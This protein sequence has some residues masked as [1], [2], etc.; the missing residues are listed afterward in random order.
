MLQSSKTK[1]K[2]L[3]VSDS[4]IDAL[5]QPKTAE[6]ISREETEILSPAS[7]WIFE[8]SVNQGS[9][10]SAKKRLFQIVNLDK[11]WVEVKLYQ[12]SL[13]TLQ[14]LQ[15]FQ[16]KVTG[17]D[18]V[19]TAKKLLLY[20]NINPKEATATLRLEIDNPD[21]KLK[22]GM[23]ATITSLGSSQSRLTL[24][25]S[26]V[27]RKNG[28]WYAFLRTQFKGEYEPV[29][30]SVKAID[31]NSYEVLSGLTAEDEVVN[32]ALFM[33]DSDAQISGLY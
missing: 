18:R 11:V 15:T 17:S 27:I 2:L 9:A 33:M 6:S 14:T 32:N 28:Q 25:R 24:P 30:I 1:L 23:Y 21:G 19:Y 10:F 8:K 22:P 29:A 3:G 7:G 31:I 13:D 5:S 26:A 4:E 12:E 16:I 20:P